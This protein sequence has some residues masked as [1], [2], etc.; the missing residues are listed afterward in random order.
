MALGR[1]DW[2]WW[3]KV[4]IVLAL[5]GCGGGGGTRVAG[6]IDFTKARAM[7]G[8]YGAYLREHKN[9]PPPNEQAFRDY[10]GTKQEALERAGLSLEAMFVSPRNGQP[11]VWIFGR[12][13]PT[14]QGGMEFIAYEKTPVDGKRLV[15]AT[16]GMFEE[17]DE[18]R[19]RTVFPNT[20]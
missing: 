6:G 20:P 16:R 19:F 13:L 3:V 15:I 7:P 11:L 18:A 17:M 10:L 12:K 1:M 8:L 4:A 2:D 5:A 14:G 9:Q